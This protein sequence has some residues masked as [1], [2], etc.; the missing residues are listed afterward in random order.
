[1]IRNCRCSSPDSCTLPKFLRIARPC[2][3][4]APARQLT[5]DPFRLSPHAVQA[6]VTGL[7]RTVNEASE[8]TRND[9]LHWAACR[10]GEMVATGELSDA[11]RAADAL[12]HVAATTGLDG[13]EIH[14]TIRSGFAKS[15]VVV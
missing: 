8:G 14:G 1:M 7:L 15:G 2:P 3:P 4:R 10:V 5:P 12:S 13:R 11:R 9:T 6:R